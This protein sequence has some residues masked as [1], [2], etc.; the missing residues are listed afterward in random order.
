MTE[1]RTPRKIALS[2]EPLI[3]ALRN[4]ADAA[5]AVAGSGHYGHI[6]PNGILYIAEALERDAEQ[7]KGLWC[8][9]CI[10]AR[11]ITGARPVA[12]PRLGGRLKPVDRSQNPLA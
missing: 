5:V 1:K 4:G 3:R 6:E 8:E 12:L 10:G 11:P 7:L 9:L 2:M